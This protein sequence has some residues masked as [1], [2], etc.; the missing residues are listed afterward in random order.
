MAAARLSAGSWRSCS[1]WLRNPELPL[2]RFTA[3][4]G[5]EGAIYTLA[6]GD[7][8]RVCLPH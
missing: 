3:K 5:E 8:L 1:S 2:E 6:G 7:G 4:W